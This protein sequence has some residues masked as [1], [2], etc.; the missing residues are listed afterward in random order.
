MLTLCFSSSRRQSLFQYFCTVS[1]AGAHSLCQVYQLLFLIPLV[2][3]DQKK[4]RRQLKV[5]FVSKIRDSPADIYVKKA[6]IWHS[7]FLSHIALAELIQGLRFFFEKGKCNVYG[8]QFRKRKFA[9][10]IGKKNFRLVIYLESLI[11]KY[12]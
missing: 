4:K 9:S 5:V 11:I 8:V 1:A 12:K 2:L 6:A 7:F 10:F 3:T